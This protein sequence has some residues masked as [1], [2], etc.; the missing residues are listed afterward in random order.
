M[1]KEFKIY[2]LNE[3]GVFPAWIVVKVVENL[4]RHQK[5]ETVVQIVLIYIQG[6][7]FWKRNA[8]Y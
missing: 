5:K 1:H 3:L 6:G 8:S 4:S 7:R 2:Y